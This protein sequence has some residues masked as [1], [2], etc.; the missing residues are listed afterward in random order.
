MD[1]FE[2][3][4]CTLLESD[5]Y[6]VRRSFKVGMSSDE[7]RATGKHTI[8]RPEIDLLAF[9]FNENKVIA[10]EVKSFLDSTGVK[11]DDLKKE[12]GK[13]EGRYKLFTCKVLRDVVLNSLRNDLIKQGMANSETQVVLG[14]VAGKV[15]QKRSAEIR[16]VMDSNGWFFWS[17][18]E[19]KEKVSKLADLPYENDPAIIAAKVLLR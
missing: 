7:K 17:P 10:L 9:K 13:A 4:I 6:W 12:H 5:G 2:S 14:L 16:Q 1:H 19:V 18:E 8:P 15:Y 3:L 11:L